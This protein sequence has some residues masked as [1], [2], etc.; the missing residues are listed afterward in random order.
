[1]AVRGGVPGHA[2]PAI[3]VPGALIARQRLDLDFAVDPRQPLEL[4]A[5]HG[6]FQ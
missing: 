1:M 4:L 2:V 6:G 5:H 3:G